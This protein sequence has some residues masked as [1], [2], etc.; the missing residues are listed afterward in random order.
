MIDQ[1]KHIIELIKLQ[2]GERVLD[3]GSGPGFLASEIGKIVGPSG[4]VCG[5]DIS[6]TLLNVAKARSA[7]QPWVEFLNGDAARLPYL[8][9]SFDIGISTQ[10]LE[11][12]PAVNAVLIELFRV[13]RQGGRVVLLDTDWDSIVWHS[14]D[15]ARMHRILSVWEEHTADA[16]LPR[17][18]SHKLIQAGFQIESQQVI[19]M[20]NPVFDQNT[21]SNRLIDLIVSFVSDRKGIS[22][23]EADAWAG[24]L[25]QLGENAEYFFS[26]NRYLFIATKP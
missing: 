20:F 1:R 2:P 22:R 24:E 4:Q 6:E 23:A 21:F 16:H 9:N 11:Y 18:L 13:L 12:V 5:I 17:T 25:R 3:V 10:V 19:P 26:L 14:T 15:N 7:H 8:N